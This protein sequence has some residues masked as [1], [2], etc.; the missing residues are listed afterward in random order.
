M[1]EVSVTVP[2]MRGVMVNKDKVYRIFIFYAHIHCQL[3]IE[4]SRM[5]NACDGVDE[6]GIWCVIKC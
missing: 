4:I 3:A 2:G 6:G 5:S 1:S